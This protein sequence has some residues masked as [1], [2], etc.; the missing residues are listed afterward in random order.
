MSKIKPINIASLMM[1]IWL[2][3][4]IFAVFFAAGWADFLCIIGCTLP[5][6]LFKR[7]HRGETFGA[8]DCNVRKYRK[9]EYA[10][11][12]IFGI[13]LCAVVSAIAYL[14]F[15]SGE[16]GIG[17]A[18]TDFA[19]LLVFGCLIPAFFEEWLVR[20]GVL[21]AI[22]VY[23]AEAVWFCSIFF[24][25]MHA[26]TTKYAYAFVAGFMITS[27]VY[28]TECIYIGMLMHFLN[29]FTSLLLS[30]L[31]RGNP[32]YIALALV[33]AVCVL[34]FKFLSKTRLFEDT[35]EIFMSVK[36]ETAPLTEKENNLTPLFYT[37]VLLAI[38][39]M[40][41]RVI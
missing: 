3:F 8:R 21:G 23:G 15:S 34:S 26:Q 32:E 18:R 35:K 9:K 39:V 10:L 11:F 30:K 4:Y 17:A 28:L 33:F 24:M 29:N 22:K 16:T 7:K 19:Y 31:P 20:G 40:L 38:G 14:L 1:L 12:M 13:S 5:M 37:F 2:A 27:L 41:L 36:Q 25:L 6:L